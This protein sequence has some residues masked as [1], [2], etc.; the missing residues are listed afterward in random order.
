MIL[1][2]TAISACEDN[3][4]SLVLPERR[5]NRKANYS[6]VQQML[7]PRPASRS[8]TPQ[9]GVA[10]EGVACEGVAY[11]KN[12]SFS[13]WLMR[14]IGASGSFAA[15]AGLRTTPFAMRVEPSDTSIAG[16]GAGGAAGG[17]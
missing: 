14:R 16:A 13:A 17:G 3:R 6:Q 12:A 11:E 4:A 5:I 15:R 9:R 1:V 10:C 8:F 7:Q 2:L